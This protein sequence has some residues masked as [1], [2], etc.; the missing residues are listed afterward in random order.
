MFSC[1]HTKSWWSLGIIYTGT[2]E[3]ISVLERVYLPRF[4]FG[5]GGKSITQRK[6]I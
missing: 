2:L 1:L 3:H 5:A 4:F 6:P